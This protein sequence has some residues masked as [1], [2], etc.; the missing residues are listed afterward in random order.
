MEGIY[1][2]VKVLRGI[3]PGNSFCRRALPCGGKSIFNF[4]NCVSLHI[5]PVEDDE[6]K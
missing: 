5:I 1:I 2:R 3:V 6:R 4:S